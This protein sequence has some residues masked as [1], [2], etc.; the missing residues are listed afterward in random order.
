MIACRITELTWLSGTGTRFCS[1][2]V[3]IRLPSAAKIRLRTCSGS[4]SSSCGNAS[5]V[6]DIF[7]VP[8]STRPVNGITSPAA[9]APDSTL[10]PMN[11]FNDRTKLRPPLPVASTLLR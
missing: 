7:C 6:S 4:V 2:T 1:N 10:T 9:S 11:L 3:A 8:R 5:T